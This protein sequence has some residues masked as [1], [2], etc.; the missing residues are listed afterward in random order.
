MPLSTG[1]PLRDSAVQLIRRISCHLRGH[2]LF[3][4]LCPP[5]S[6]SAAP[7]AN[8]FA[9]FPVIYVDTRCFPVSVHRIPAPQLLWPTDSPDFMPFMWTHAVFRSLSTRFPL[10]SSSGQRIRQI[11]CHLCGHT[12]F[13]GLCPPDSRSAA[14]LAN[15]VL[16]YKLPQKK[17]R[18]NYRKEI[19][20]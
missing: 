14:P 11:S 6:H 8:G 5:D 12:L 9:G 2:S 7:L 16:E 19:T 18:T 13:F 1:F 20:G 4:S 3:L 10:R 17:R 15:C